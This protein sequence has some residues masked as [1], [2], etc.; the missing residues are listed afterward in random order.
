MTVFDGN[1]WL[2]IANV[3]NGAAPRRADGGYPPY[4][5]ELLPEGDG[6]SEILRIM[7]A[8]AGFSR[9]ELDVGLADGA[10]LI[11]GEK[12]DEGPKDY[13]HHGIAGRRFKRTFALVNGVEVR[14]AELHNGLLTIEL[15]RPN[16]EKHALKVGI[17]CVS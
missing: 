12:R 5:V 7:L 14:K 4:N 1:V 6:D 16:R 9:D 11:R 2:S 17:T 15:E 8:V 3:R 10:L 13:L